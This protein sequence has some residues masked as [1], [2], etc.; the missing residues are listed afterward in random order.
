MIHSITSF[1]LGI[2]PFTRIRLFIPTVVNNES[3]EQSLD[4]WGVLNQPIFEGSIHSHAFVYLF[5]R[6]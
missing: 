1:C 5:P 3:C 4:L 6:L 2:N